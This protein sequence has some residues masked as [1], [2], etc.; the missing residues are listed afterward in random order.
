MNSIE[1]A[2]ALAHLERALDKKNNK[3]L[4]RWLHWLLKQ[5]FQGLEAD[6]FRL[7]AAERLAEA[8]LS[9][10][11]LTLLE[12]MDW[13]GRCAGEDLLKGRLERHCGKP[14]AA[15]R[16]LAMAL[17]DPMLRA[18]AAYQLGEVYRSLGDFDSAARW[19]M[20]SLE[21]DSSDRVTHNSLQF[22]R[23]SSLQLD[24]VVAL[25]QR[26][27]EQDPEKS[28]PR[29]LLAFHLA[30][31]GDVAAAIKQCQRASRSELGSRQAWLAPD[32]A[33]AKLPEALI[34]GVPKGGT[35]SLLAWLAHHPD[36][37]CHPRKELHFFDRDWHLGPDLYA[38]Q[39][40][41]FSPSHP[42][43]RLEATPNYF[44]HPDVP[45]RVHGLMPKARLILLL[46]DPVARAQ[47]WI[48]HLKRH[49]GLQGNSELWLRQE[50]QLLRKAKPDELDQ[51]VF[52]W[53][54]AIWGSCYDPCL[55][56]WQRFFPDNQMLVLSSESL[57]SQPIASLQQVCSFL[58]ISSLSVWPP[59]RAY[60]QSPVEA[61]PLSQPLQLELKDFLDIHNQK[62]HSLIR[63]LA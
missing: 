60:N 26:L 8:R 54:N 59:L 27:V 29:Q 28:L 15:I 20:Q 9:P 30:T 52:R 44:Q 48:E 37:W 33:P 6:K 12:P 24:Q 5:R 51:L 50:Y 21:A 42:L 7:L 47:S 53:P 35:S 3:I 16:S 18:T 63:R 39:F 1:I 19:F 62:A 49:E 55:K 45:A 22:T 58:E 2:T 23:F 11:A 25:Y 34:I 17:R 13:Q 4:L 40:P 57:F 10:L 14:L 32:D 46:R 56:R 43:L 41:R 61:P 31:R 36:L 38:S